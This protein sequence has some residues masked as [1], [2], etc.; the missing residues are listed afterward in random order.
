MPEKTRLNRRSVIEKV[1]IGVTG[2]TL[3]AVGLAGNVSGAVSGVCT[4]DDVP[5]YHQWDAEPGTD[6]TYT[7][8][9][10]DIEHGASLLYCGSAE[11][12]F[13][14]TCNDID[15]ADYYHIFV[16]TGRGAARSWSDPDE[17]AYTIM[18]HGF[19]ITDKSNVYGTFYDVGDE[20]A[21]VSPG[22]TLDEGGDPIDLDSEAVE[23]AVNAMSLVPGFGGL[24]LAHQI[25]TLPNNIYSKYFTHEDTAADVCHQ[26]GIG[27]ATGH[28][29]EFTIRSQT[30]GAQTHFDIMTFGDNDASVVPKGGN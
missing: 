24:G 12:E 26:I 22:D 7:P 30:E 27:I 13:G 3:G 5:I 15:G 10:S 14:L 25:A 6:I 4:A 2:T 28:D 19:S 20:S 18:E 9:T 21:G 11:C 23:F 29:A 17:E 1:G 16:L 8:E